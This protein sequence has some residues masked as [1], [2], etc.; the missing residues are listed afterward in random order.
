MSENPKAQFILISC[1]PGAESALKQ[2]TA[3]RYP[4]LKLAYSRP[5]FVTFKNSGEAFTPSFVLES[6]FAQSFA[7][8]VGKAKNKDEVTAAVKQYG[9]THVHVWRPRVSD[10]GRENR[11]NIVDRLRKQFTNDDKSLAFDDLVLDVVVVGDEEWWLG[12]HTH[13]SAH[14]PWPGG[15][16]E[17]AM[18]PM[19]PSR[20]YLKLEEALAWAG[21][22]PDRGDLALE[23][24]SAP[25]GASFALLERRLKVIG[26]DPGKMAEQVLN[27]RSGFKFI[28]RQAMQLEPDQIKGVNW[29]FSDMNVSGADTVKAVKKLL[30]AFASTLKGGVITLKL[31]SWDEVKEVSEW[32]NELDFLM[33][34]LNSRVA[35]L[36]NHRSE[37]GFGFVKLR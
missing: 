26:V 16:F 3:N 5:G 31:A 11:D 23:L 7:I 25:G 27:H 15:Q 1:Q 24:G 22:R 19:A 18:P 36:Y 21:L 33:K 28:H 2:E 14:R 34:P 4:N 10:E 17:K 35:H 30:P 9:A 6:F 37:L 12:L 20:A 8:S 13:S 32:V 29:L